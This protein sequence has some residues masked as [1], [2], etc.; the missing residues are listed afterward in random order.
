MAIIISPRVGTPG[1]EFDEA[2]AAAE[3]VN[4]QALI[5]GGFIS[6][7]KPSRSGKNKDSNS[8]QE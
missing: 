1:E 3:G 5:D 7:S 2:K 6:T 8:E 4:V